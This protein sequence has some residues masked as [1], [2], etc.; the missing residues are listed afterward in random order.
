MNVAS[1]GVVALAQELRLEKALVFIDLETTGTSAEHDRIVEFAAVKIQPDGR[2]TQFV[3]R[4]NPGVPIPQEATAIHGI[5]DAAIASAPCFADHARSIAR[6]LQGCDV[7]GYNVRSFDLRLLSAEMQRAGVALDLSL[8]RVL[9]PLAIFRRR[10]PRDLASALRLYCGDQVAAAYGAI[11]HG[12]LP[13]T[14][15]TIDVLIGQLRRYPDLPRDVAEL[16]AYCVNRQ[17]HWIDDGGK[18]IWRAGEA[19]V[20]F[21]KNVGRSLRALAADEPDYL[22]WLLRQDFSAEVKGI[23]QAALRGEFPTAPT[24]QEAA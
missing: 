22:R 10:E 16:H 7:A 8:A 4:F 5:D 11:A 3:Q 14:L 2:V 13:D 24:T 21:G 19:C 20:G 1:M 6:A 17:P 9:D 15:A 23:V 18:I 12:A